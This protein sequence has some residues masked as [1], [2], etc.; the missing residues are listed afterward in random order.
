MSTFEIEF[1]LYKNE[2]REGAQPPLGV[3]GSYEGRVVDLPSFSFSSPSAPKIRMEDVEYHNSCCPELELFD[4][5]LIKN[6]VVYVPSGGNGMRYLF[7]AKDLIG[8]TRTDIS[9][10]EIGRIVLFKN[11][12]YFAGGRIIAGSEENGWV[13]KT[14]CGYGTAIT[15]KSDAIAGII[16]SFSI[17]KAI[18]PVWPDEV[19]AE[20]NRT[21]AALS[22]RLAPIASHKLLQQGRLWDVLKRKYYKIRLRNQQ[23][24]LLN[25]L[26]NNCEAKLSVEIH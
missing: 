9:L 26:A 13:I 22:S 1:L 16:E 21:I 25:Y 7:G 20:Y 15:K 8:V 3:N 11:G 6:K 18:Y 12:Q 5:A 19:A 17:N 10:L 23:R 14:D 2:F 24:D 4:E